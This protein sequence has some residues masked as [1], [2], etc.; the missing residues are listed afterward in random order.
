[1]IANS[2]KSTARRAEFFEIAK[3]TKDRDVLKRLLASEDF[4]WFF[5]RLLRTCKVYQDTYTGDNDTFRNEGMRRIGL[6]LLKQV[7][8]LGLEG[9][10]LKQLAEIEH[11]NEAERMLKKI[12]EKEK[13]N[14]AK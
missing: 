13:E 7:E 1:M 11:V 12:R 8:D 10:K 6:I 5:L 14:N 3:A 9:L 4:R 2:D